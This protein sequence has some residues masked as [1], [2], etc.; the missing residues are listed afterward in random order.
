MNE[1]PNTLRQ[2]TRRH[3]FQQSGFG[4]GALAYDVPG[5]KHLEVPA[6]PMP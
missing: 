4:I 5:T 1:Q 2:V 3:F 6:C